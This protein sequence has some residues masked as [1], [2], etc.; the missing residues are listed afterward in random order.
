[1]PEIIKQRQQA[2]L[3]LGNYLPVYTTCHFTRLYS[4]AGTPESS[5]AVDDV[6]ALLFSNNT[7]P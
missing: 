4:T 3:K 5:R 1:M 6:V 2:S 7:L